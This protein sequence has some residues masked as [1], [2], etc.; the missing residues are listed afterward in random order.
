MQQDVPRFF[1]ISLLVIALLVFIIFKRISA[2]LLSIFTIPLSVVAT[3]GTMGIYTPVGIILALS[4]SLTLLPALLAVTPIKQ[5]RNA[6]QDKSLLG[7]FEN[8]LVKTGEFSVNKPWAIFAIFGILI[9]I[10]A[11]GISQPNFYYNPVEWHPEDDVLRTDLIQIDKDLGGSHSLEIYIDT[12]KS[13][14]VV[15][16]EFL[17]R[18]HKAQK[19]ADQYRGDEGVK[20]TKSLS[21]V[22]IIREINQALNGSLMTSY[23]I[24]LLLITPLMIAVVG[25]VKAGLSSMIPNLT[26]ITI[27]LGLMGWAGI[28]LNPFTLMIASIAIGLAVDDTIH[29]MQVCRKLYDE[30]GNIHRA[31]EETLR[32]T[33][34]ALV[35]TSII[36]SSA[37]FTYLFSSLNNLFDFG[38]L[39]GFAIIIALLADLTI[40]P[41]LMKL[42]LA[43]KEPASRFLTTEY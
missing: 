25:E 42:H 4:I 35:F 1:G 34:R 5:K 30:T 28:T 18:L 24:A 16:P 41:A 6:R 21:I 43:K 19:T 31:V 9:I 29:F 3:L 14:G 39:T 11:V 26:P 2:V 38:L 37:F 12:H 27:T 17:Q 22:D 10:S 13:G 36:L 15:E 32:S 40:A 33:G 7:I 23:I 8:L 20:I